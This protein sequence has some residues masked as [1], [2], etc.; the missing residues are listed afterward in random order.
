M[1]RVDDLISAF[2]GEVDATAKRA[3]SAEAAFLGI[4]RAL[5]DDGLQDPAVV[6]TRCAEAGKALRFRL[7]SISEMEATVRARI[8]TSSIRVDILVLAG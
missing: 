2:K 3:K 1:D 8:T 5:R 6:I 4:Y 7:E